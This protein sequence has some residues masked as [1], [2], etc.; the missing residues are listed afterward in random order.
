MTAVEPAHVLVSGAGIAGCAAA[1]SLAATGHTVTLIEPSTDTGKRFAGEWLHPPGVR[2]LDRLGVAWRDLPHRPG[3]GFAVYPDDGLHPIVLPYPG[4]LTALACRHDLLLDRIRHTAAQQPKVSLLYGRRV[5]AGADGY[6]VITGPT[7]PNPVPTRGL[8]IRAEGRTAQSGPSHPR[9]HT[10]GL[11]LDDVELPLE[12]FAHVFAAGPSPV[13]AYAINEGQV[14]MT[15]D[16]PAHLRRPGKPYDLHDYRQAM[17][18]PLLACAEAALRAGLGRWSANRSQPRS[19]YTTTPHAAFVGD[20]VGSHHPLSACGMTLALL[21]GE[22]IGAHAVKTYSLIRRWAGA[23]PEATALTLHKILADADGR[24]P[25]R[26]GLFR[27]WRSSPSAA[28]HSM[29]LLAMEENSL[30]RFS[31]T[32]LEILKFAIAS[33]PRSGKALL[34]WTWWTL[35]LLYRLAAVRTN[36][37]RG[38]LSRYFSR[39]R[40]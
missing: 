33:K 20:A 21:D 7:P 29:Q 35:R 19:Q 6:P 1:L 2:A 39:G 37:V 40:A 15:I 9:S 5:Q 8:W 24:D 26:Q 14:R 25:V 36:R 11:L 30:R 3:L 17:P 27:M 4:G 12:D 31:Y 10:L 32:M 34:A 22:C 18:A 23:V 16:V 28:N 13:L 38:G